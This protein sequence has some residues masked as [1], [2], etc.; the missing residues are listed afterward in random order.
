MTA[1]AALP[2]QHLS[3]I[4]HSTAGPTGRTRTKSKQQL[5]MESQER[6]DTEK[7]QT[8]NT[9]RAAAAARKKTKLNALRKEDVSLG[10]AI[11]FIIVIAATAIG[12]QGEGDLVPLHS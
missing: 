9:K 10:G 8:A 11:R 3:Q 6:R 2:A 4:P 12:G 1:P 5:Q 7:K